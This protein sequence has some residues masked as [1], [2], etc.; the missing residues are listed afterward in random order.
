MRS[1]SPEFDRVIRFAARCGVSVHLDDPVLPPDRAAHASQHASW[2]LDR[3][4]YWNDDRDRPYEAAALLHEV[5]H[6]VDPKP[7]RRC[8]EVS[9]PLLAFEF[10]AGR[11][12]K[13]PRKD[14]MQDYGVDGGDWSEMTSHDKHRLIL[15][16][17]KKAVAWGTLDV[18]GRP[19]Y[20]RPWEK[21]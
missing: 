21:K 15:T 2:I 18:Q 12:L 5:A 20:R 19:T 4:I 14:W 7:P 11:L 3:A 16:S 6:C 17:L 10:F 8:N 13:T 9:G 1:R